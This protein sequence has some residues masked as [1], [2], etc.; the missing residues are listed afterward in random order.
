MSELKGYA[1]DGS[2]SGSSLVA[3]LSLDAY[4]FPVQILIQDASGYVVSSINANHIL[5]AEFNNT[6][7]FQGFHDP[8]EFVYFHFL[9]QG[10][11]KY[12]DIFK[13]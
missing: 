3:S 13:D 11:K 6:M 7:F 10:L 9:E 8:A 12:R 5:D 4:T 1:G 2:V